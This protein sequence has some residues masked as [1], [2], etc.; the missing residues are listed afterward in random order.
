MEN[1]EKTTL[2]QFAYV[3]WAGGYIQ[4]VGITPE[5]AQLEGAGDEQDSYT[6]IPV[7]QCTKAVYDLVLKEGGRVTVRSAYDANG[8][9]LICTP[10]EYAM[11][12]D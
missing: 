6:R 8:N 12:K 7:T 5:A 9:E 3:A 10:E 4:G 1:I 2:E 11:V